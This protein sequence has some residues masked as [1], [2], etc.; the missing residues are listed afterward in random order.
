MNRILVV[1]FF[2]VSEGFGEKRFG[3]AN[4]SPESESGKF[5]NNIEMR[6][7]VVR[8]AKYDRTTG[9]LSQ[10]GIEAARQRGESFLSQGGDER[11]ILKGY[12]SGYP[13]AQQTVDEIVRSINVAPER[14][15]VQR[16]NIEWGD[17][18]DDF[19]I[20]NMAEFLETGEAEVDGKKI[21][22][23]ELARD[24]AKRLSTFVRMS[25]RLKNDSK[26]DIVNV[27]HLPWIHAF[28]R[29]AALEE[30]QSISPS[31]QGFLVKMGGDVGLTEGF[32]L[33]ID[34]QTKNEVDLT[35][36]FRGKEIALSYERL[37]D[38]AEKQKE[39]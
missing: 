14:K 15:G 35:L 32:S 29:E 2:M 28:L 33:A 30:G 36:Q 18:S 25:S 37:K 3:G 6:V 39:G 23:Q 10:E 21:T 1:I 24:V 12:A 7:E 13:R 38:L 9:D 17:P 4:V 31:G 26:V 22:T 34:R 19:Y 11:Y 27:T 8:H 5:G 20:G 16:V